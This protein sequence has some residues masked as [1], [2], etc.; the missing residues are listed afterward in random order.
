MLLCCCSYCC[1][2]SQYP[3]YIRVRAVVVLEGAVNCSVLLGYEPSVLKDA[4]R[5]WQT[6]GVIAGPASLWL[7][8]CWYRLCHTFGTKGALV[9]LMRY[10]VFLW[11]LCE[12]RVSESLFCKVWTGGFLVPLRREL[13]HCIHMSVGS[14]T[15]S[16]NWVG[17]DIDVELKSLWFSGALVNP[18]GNI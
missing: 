1:W 10:W 13:W 3:V 18:Q 2:Y 6:A 4:G 15:L 14:I 12:R 16:G 5:G 17:F 11:S 9:H 7:K 8:Q